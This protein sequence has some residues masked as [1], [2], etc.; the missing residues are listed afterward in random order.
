MAS[1][2]RQKPQR[3]R[4]FRIPLLSLAAAALALAA[5]AAPAGAEVVY[6]NAPTVAAAEVPSLGFEQTGTAELGSLVRLAGAARVDP[7]IRVGAVVGACGEGTL[8][9]GCTTPGATFPLPAT[10]SVYAVGADGA[11]AQLLARQTQSFELGY[12]GLL[13]PLAF[14]LPGLTLPG[15]AIL[16]VAFDTRSSG[17]EPTGVAGPPDAVGVALAGPPAA[18]ATPREAEGV[19][20]AASSEAGAV[21]VFAFEAEAALWQ[22]RQPA[23]T[24]EAS[25]PAAA[26]PQIAPAPTPP[27]ATRPFRREVTIPPGKRMTVSFPR[28]SAR[29]AGPGALVQV[30]C[31]GASAARCIGTLSLSAAGTVHKAPY[32]IS[33]GRRQYVVVPLGS[34]LELLDRLDAP[35]ATATA[36]TVQLGG[37]AVKTK[38]ALKLK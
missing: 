35:R 5:F 11:P 34:D 12:E 33:K 2:G 22:N 10:L 13:Q 18:G 21:P 6:D 38:R 23:F 1:D 24:V 30:K 15:E 9:S 26:A 3:G 37:A 36:S 19:Y 28:A 4:A 32:S 25:A 8:E 27:T 31:S 14:S 17:Y 7:Q 29:I 16:S 20:R